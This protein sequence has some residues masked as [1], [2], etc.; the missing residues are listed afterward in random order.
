MNRETFLKSL[1]LTGLASTLSFKTLFTDSQKPKSQ[2]TGGNNNIV[3]ENQL[4]QGPFPVDEVPGWEVVMTT[5]PSDRIIKNFGMGLVTYVIDEVGPPNVQSESLSTSIEK[6]AQ[7]PFGQKLYMRVNWKDL[8]QV[9]GKLAPSRAWKLTFKMAEKYNKRISFRVMLDN[10]DIPGSALPEFLKQKVPVVTLGKTNKVGLPGKVQTVPRY[11]SPEFQNAFK[12]F[13]DLLASK[14]NGHPHVEYMDTYMYGFWGEGHTWPFTKSA[15]PD[16]IIARETFN[17][18]FQHQLDNW[19]K[20]PLTTNTQP[21][22]NDVGNHSILEKTL[23]TKNWLRSDT[24]F[25]ENQQIDELS[26]RPANIG[27]ALEVG[28]SDGK[29]KDVHLFNGQPKTADEIY[30]VMDVNANYYSLWNWHHISADGVLR[31]YKKYPRAIDTIAR[32][33]GYRIRPSWVWH[34]EKEHHNGLIFG[35]SNDGLAGVPGAV[36]LTLKTNRGK[37]VDSGYLDP[38]YP[39]PTGVRQARM[40]LPKGMDWKGLRLYAQINVKGQ[41]YPIEWASREKPN[42][43]GSLTIT[44][45][46]YVNS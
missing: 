3:E 38:G 41:L 16:S 30:H 37:I 31:Y 35:F 1:G 20:V 43:D 7:I 6:L 42:A 14:Y 39:H 34:F 12:E 36:K 17:N 46:P 33:I 13:D 24:I 40:M 10:P 18:M 8:Q 25:I 9:P 29:T 23:R 4:Y 15:F 5:T 22:F 11:D 28:M 2:F 21:D 27:A 26:N 44:P 32:K 19:D 45:T